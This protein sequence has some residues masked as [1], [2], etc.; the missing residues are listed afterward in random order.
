MEAVKFPSIKCTCETNEELNLKWEKVLQKGNFSY[1]FLYKDEND[2][3][4]LIK[5]FYPCYYKELLNEKNTIEELNQRINSKNIIKFIGMGNIFIYDTYYENLFNFLKVNKKINFDNQVPIN[6]LILDYK[7][8]IDLFDAIKDETKNIKLNIKNL[9]NFLFSL[10]DLLHTHKIA[11][12]DIK[13][14]NI[15]FN[16]N[17]FS[18]IDFGLCFIENFS[19]SPKNVIG[20]NYYIPYKYLQNS[21]FTYSS[22]KTFQ[23]QDL[24]GCFATLYVCIRKNHPY[25]IK[26]YNMLN[27]MFVSYNSLNFIDYEYLLNDNDKTF[28]EKLINLINN[29]FQVYKKNSDYDQLY[30]EYNPKKILQNLELLFKE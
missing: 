14:E 5:Y 16:E 2:N 27:H 30:E 13:P 3:D 10:I 15:I 22:F 29:F 24:Y 4:Y 18:I 20:S 25:D 1:T 23:F 6:Y 28:M 26:K 17:E 11:H 19:T 8:G 21:S 9:V 12:M 7:K